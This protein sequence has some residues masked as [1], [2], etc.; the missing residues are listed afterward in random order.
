MRMSDSNKR[1]NST[2]AAELLMFI[3]QGPLKAY[4]RPYEQSEAALKHSSLTTTTTSSSYQLNWL[5][6]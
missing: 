5:L 4:R 1:Y 3:I 2:Y 6:L